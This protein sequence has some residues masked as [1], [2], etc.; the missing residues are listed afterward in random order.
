MRWTFGTHVG[1]VTGI[2]SL[3]FIQLLTDFIASVYALGLLGTHIPPEIASVPLLLAPFLL[4]ALRRA[5][6]SAALHC[7]ALCAM[8]LRLA[9]PLLPT[10]WRMMASGAGVA[11]LL[12]VFPLLLA[13]PPAAL[14][15]S[16]TVL[17]SVGAGL[18]LGIGLCNLLRAIGSGADFSTHGAGQTIA[19]A[20]AAI[21]AW[22]LVAGRKA[23]AKAS[24]D[25]SSVSAA[26]A[27][28][29]GFGR[30][31]A[32]ALGV[33]ASFTLIY[34]VLAA[35]N[36][37]ARW[38]VLPYELVLGI[39]FAS[40]A[41]F[42][43]ICSIRRIL[44]ALLRP[45]V[46]IVL[47]LAFVA[48]FGLGLFLLRVHFPA[49]PRAYP[50]EPAL[51]GLAACLLALLALALSPV[52]IADLLVFVDTICASKP[53]PRALGCAFG[54]AAIFLLLLVFA[55]VFTTAYDYI[56]AVG[57]FFRDAYWLVHLAAALGAL[58]C[59]FV[60]LR[61]VG[62]AGGEEGGR[63]P[64]KKIGDGP[65]P[66]SGFLALATLVFGAAAVA[67]TVLSPPAVPPAV[68]SGLRVLAYNIQQGCD[69]AGNKNHDGQL[70]LMKA[71]GADV[72]GIE[73]CDTNR[74]AGAND[75]LPRVLACGLG[76]YSFYGPPPQAGTFGIALLSKHPIE[77]PRV[78][79]MYSKGEQTAAILARVTSAGNRYTIL[80][81]HLGNAGDWIQQ[82][83]VLKELS[84][85]ENVVA[86]GDFN[87]SPR[88]PQF[89]RTTAVLA[90]SWAAA[91]SKTADDPAFD[92]SGRIDHVFVSPDL[93][94]K[95]A[96]F[97]NAPESDHPAY[98]VE[99]ED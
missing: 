70:A 30:T 85:K 6:G 55:Q 16:R 60:V 86:M 90:D 78:F 28:P 32:C 31:L 66:A 35:V 69:A 22:I 74:V 67:W 93:Q 9:E 56:P 58:L 73:E 65:P 15:L 25:V 91:A 23:P 10:R 98:L 52:L 97:I 51:A 2:L 24:A 62:R 1:A 53:S 99:I 44:E 11:L 96:R 50:F 47:N 83:A 82:E 77:E 7:L 63:E 92:P 8:A 29:G 33:A 21:A 12:L 80:V 79:Y 5:P 72:I 3:F 14:R 75:D 54:L 71:A 39:L 84:G 81:T 61:G 37:V 13:L 68:R 41:G 40:L 57:P 20:L 87:F 18:A 46:L 94:V 26:G 43:A 95:S 48:A 45:G 34:F 64:A 38:A 42:A 59:I 17:P 36:V 88:D 76:M 89:A 49:D 4:L 19:W 27:P